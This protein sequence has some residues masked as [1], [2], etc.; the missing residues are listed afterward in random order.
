MKIMKDFASDGVTAH[1][2]KKKVRAENRRMTSGRKKV[3]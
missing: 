3:R 2:D 1:A